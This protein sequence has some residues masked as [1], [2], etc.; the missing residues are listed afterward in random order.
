MADMKNPSFR[1]ATKLSSTK[2]AKCLPVHITDTHQKP[3]KSIK[4]NKEKTV[5]NIQ[6][7]IVRNE[8]HVFGFAIS[9]HRVL[10]LLI[11]CVILVPLYILFAYSSAQFCIVIFIFSVVPNQNDK[12][13]LNSAPE[14]KQTEEAKKYP[15]LNHARRKQRYAH[16]RS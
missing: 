14:E 7:S 3:K 10:S 13:P 5:I 16:T 8:L 6:I 15:Q 12:L 1:F 2:G 4:Q 9:T 11:G